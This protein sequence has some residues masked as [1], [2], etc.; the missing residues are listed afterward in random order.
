MTKYKNK[1]ELEKSKKKVG[2][3]TDITP[4]DKQKKKCLRLERTDYIQAL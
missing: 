4:H 1:K 3:S 2:S